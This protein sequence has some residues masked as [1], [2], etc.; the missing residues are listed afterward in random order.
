LRK[1]N[2][3]EL[4]KICGFP[5]TYVIPQHVN[6]YDLFGNMV[7]PPVVIELLKQVYG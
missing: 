3:K 5:N 1:L 4:K 7:T 6:A 2:I